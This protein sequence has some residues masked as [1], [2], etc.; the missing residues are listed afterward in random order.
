MDNEAIEKDGLQTVKGLL[1]KLGGWPILEGSNWNETEFEWKD[2]TYKFRRLGA[3]ST[4]IV[5]AAVTINSLNSSQLIIDVC[6]S[7]L[8]FYYEVLFV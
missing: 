2:I 5:Y 7:S 4:N 6:I 8:L 3:P 1:Q